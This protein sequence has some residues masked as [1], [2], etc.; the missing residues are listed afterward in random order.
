M[1]GWH[2]RQYLGCDVILSVCKMSSL[3]KTGQNVEHISLYC[4]FTTVCEALVI[5]IKDSNTKRTKGVF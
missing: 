5:S 3:G 4:F 1:S 2:Q